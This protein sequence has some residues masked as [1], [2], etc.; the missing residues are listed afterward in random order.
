MPGPPNNR[1]MVG[2]AGIER[3]TAVLQG[4]A[5]HA[6]QR[7][8]DGLVAISSRLPY[9]LAIILP[10]Q[11]IIESSYGSRS[12]SS[13]HMASMQGDSV[14]LRVVVFFRLP[15]QTFTRRPPAD[16]WPDHVRLSDFELQFVCKGGKARRRR[17]AGFHRAAKSRP[18][19]RSSCQDFIFQMW[20]ASQSEA[21]LH[22]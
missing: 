7:A 19:I 8:N 4:A 3:R 17:P 9:G 20:K 22:R 15:L 14:A 1:R 12:D 21:N 6:A 11:A 13:K 10:T 18:A 5:R 2:R 16:R